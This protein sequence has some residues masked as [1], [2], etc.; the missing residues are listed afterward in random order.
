[1]KTS[2]QDLTYLF[3]DA[4]KNW[5]PKAISAA[6]GRKGTDLA[7]MERNMGLKNGSLRNVFYRRCRRYEWTIAKVIG[8]SPEVIWPDRYNS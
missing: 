2:R 6:L 8:V 7:T 5:S 1:M 3:I 4:G